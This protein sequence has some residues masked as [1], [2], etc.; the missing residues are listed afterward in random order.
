MSKITRPRR[1]C[2]DSSEAKKNPLCRGAGGEGNPSRIPL[3]CRQLQTEI[4]NPQSEAPHVSNAICLVVSVQ[5]QWDVRE[6]GGHFLG[7]DLC[8]WP[9][10]RRGRVSEVHAAFVCSDRVP[11]R[12][13]KLI[14]ILFLDASVSNS[15]CQV[16]R[17]RQPPIGTKLHTAGLSEV[18]FLRLAEFNHH[19]VELM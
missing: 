3:C 16:P 7:V 15:L 13:A 19:V 2:H 5:E 4:W 8:R 11:A 17:K 14:S 18:R 9:R 12:R 6:Y 10:M 1:V